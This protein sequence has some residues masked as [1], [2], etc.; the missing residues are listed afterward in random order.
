MRRLTQNQ[1]A[2]GIKINNVNSWI[3]SCMS[4]FATNIPI[5][6]ENTEVRTLAYVII[7]NGHHSA[8]AI[9]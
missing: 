3:G 2:V 6:Y 7:K 5:S 1:N 9:D 4:F 8:I